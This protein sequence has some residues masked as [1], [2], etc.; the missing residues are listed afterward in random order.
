MRRI[1]ARGVAVPPDMTGDQGTYQLFRDGKVAFYFDGRWRTP[2]F[3]GRTGFTW[4]VAPVPAGP[5]KRITQ[6]G[7]TGLAVWRKS[8]QPAAAREFLRFYASPRGARLAMQ[9]G[10]YV[11]VFRELA[12]GREFLSLRPPD[13]IVRFSET[14]EA[15]ASTTLLYAPGGQEVADVFGGRMQQVLSQPDLPATK[16]LAGLEADLNRWLAKSTRGT[17]P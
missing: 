1:N 8:P 4:D 12:F 3:A 16:I 13:S 15:G 6:H 9:A 2:D 7:G 11:P 14:M 10:R 5:V 17:A